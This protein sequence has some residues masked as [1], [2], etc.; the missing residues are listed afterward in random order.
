MTKPPKHSI[1]VKVWQ[2]RELWGWSQ[3]DLATAVGVSVPYLCLIEKGRVLPS[4][5]LLGAIAEALGIHV[6]ALLEMSALRAPIHP[7]RRRARA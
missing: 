4:L 2:L 7:R 3:A 1:Q 6:A 5:R